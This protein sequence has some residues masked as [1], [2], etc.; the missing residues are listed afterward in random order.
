MQVTEYIGVSLANHDFTQCNCQLFVMQ[1]NLYLTCKQSL[2]TC[3]YLGL[4]LWGKSTHI[5]KLVDNVEVAVVHSKVEGTP[6]KLHSTEKTNNQTTSKLHCVFGQHNTLSGEEE[7]DV[8]CSVQIT[9]FCACS[10][11]SCWPGLLNT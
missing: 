11:L 4:L 9:L 7:D 1:G 5:H 2:A 8:S 3:T 6:A 10:T